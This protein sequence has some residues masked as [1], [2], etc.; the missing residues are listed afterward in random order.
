MGYTVDISAITQRSLGEEDTMPKK[1]KPIPN[2]YHTATP[3]LI[4]DD[5]GARHR[6]LQA[7]LRRRSR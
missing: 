6:L 3:Y 2:G 4:V 7:G 5:G 1:V